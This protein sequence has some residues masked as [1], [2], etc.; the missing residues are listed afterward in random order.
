MDNINPTEAMLAAIIEQANGQGKQISLM[1]K[2]MEQI[3]KD[4]GQLVVA[5]DSQPAH[6]ESQSVITLKDHE[7]R[8]AS[9][10]K[11]I[12]ILY[13]QYVSLQKKYEKSLD[14][15]RYW[16]TQQWAKRLFRWLFLN[17]HLWIWSVA[18]FFNILFL[19]LLKVCF[20]QK[21]E[22]GN[23]E[24]ADMK[25]RYLKAVGAAPKATQ[26][27]DDTFANGD[28]RAIQIVYSTVDDY[29]KALKHK[30]DSIVRA[31][32]EKTEKLR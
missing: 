5:Q 3:A 9:V 32:Q 19:L 6:Q 2:A 13:G 22:I 24:E 31:E 28:S 11:N 10:K 20:L 25:Y 18:I 21:A 29:E 7:E 15:R 4:V 8:L 16:A 30:S 1:S 17:R 14:D 12:Q 26:S 23:Y 27:L